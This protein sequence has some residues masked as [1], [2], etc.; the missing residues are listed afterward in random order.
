MGNLEPWKTQIFHAN[1][2]EY[3]PVFNLSAFADEVFTLNQM[4]GGQDETQASL[5]KDL[6]PEILHSRDHTIKHVLHR[7]VRETFDYPLNE[8]MYEVETNAKWIPE[9]EGLYPHVH[10]SSAFSVIMYPQD[11][12]SALVFFDPRI[13]A[14]RGYPQA[15]RDKFFAKHVISP[16]AGDFYIFPSYLQ[17]SVSYV[18]EDVRLS[19]LHE[20][21][22]HNTR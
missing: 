16:K 21:Y 2:F 1:I 5:T 10:S 9:G 8:D 15:I 6:F 4:A 18:K 19:L 22:L 11:S 13:N 20:Y 7:W 3:I 17:H 12:E 14:S